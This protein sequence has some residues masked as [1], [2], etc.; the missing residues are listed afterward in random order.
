MEE[1]FYYKIVNDATN[2]VDF[3]VSVDLPV[4]SEKLCETLCL[5]GYRAEF[6]TKE[7]YEKNSVDDCE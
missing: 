7:E 4:K 6:A 1:K 2:E 3:Y 5:S